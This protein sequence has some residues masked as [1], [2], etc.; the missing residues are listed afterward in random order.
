MNPAFTGTPIGSFNIKRPLPTDGPICLNLGGAGEGFLDGRIP[1]FVTVD[2]RDCEQTDVVSDI[3]DL[4]WLGDGTVDQ[5][6][7]SN[8]LEHF[9]IYKTID[10]VKEWFRVLK[11]KG[12]MY[13]SVPDF[14]AVVK[15]YLKFGLTGW[16]QY[17]VWGD[18]KTPLN[19]HYINFTY[20][21]LSAIMA[22]AGFKD[23]KRVPK[24]HFNVNDASTH[25]DNYLKIPVSLNV[26]VFK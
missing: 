8:A 14:D 1:G 26:E 9:P 5:I 10:V 24:F 18:Q 25:E 3:S 16:V 19:Y 11:P 15:L 12:K 21:T 13:I 7:C 4:S 17:I 20:G 2:L 23:V 6:Y 22:E